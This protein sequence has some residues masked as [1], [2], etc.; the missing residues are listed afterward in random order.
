MKGKLVIGSRASKLAVRQAEIVME[1]I[2][3]CHPDIET[4]IKTYVTTGDKIL[5]QNLD[6]IGGKGLFVRELDQALMDGRI[7]IAVHSLKDMPMETPSYLPILAYSKRED[8]RDTLILPQDGQK[9]DGTGI[10]GCSS[11]RRTL[12]LKNLYPN[13]ESAGIRGNIHTRLNK[14]DAG[15][16]AA[17]VLAC[18]GLKRMGLACRISRVFAPEEML[19]AAGQGILAVQGRR[20]GG[21]EDLLLCVNDAES[22]ACAIAERAFVSAL[23]GGCIEPIAAYA[24]IAG[25]EIYLSGLYVDETGRQISGNIAGPLSE[26]RQLGETLANRLAGELI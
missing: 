18:A 2:R 5:D 9:W 17:L 15:G 24:Q 1:R 3:G 8:P 6:R 16:C 14:L 20:N 19:P 11:A 25:N 4:E 10:V 7:D 22:Q 26:A 12:Q 21:L 13:A 23:G